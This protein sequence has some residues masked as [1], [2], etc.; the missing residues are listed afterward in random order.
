M[1]DDKKVLFSSIY[2]EGKADHWFQST[3]DS[4]DRLSWEN[5]VRDLCNSFSDAGVEDVITLFKKLH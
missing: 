3:Y 5:F 1:P 2:L 4:F